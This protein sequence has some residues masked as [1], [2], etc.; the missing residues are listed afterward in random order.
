[1]RWLRAMAGVLGAG[2]VLGAVGCGSSGFN[3]QS[4][5]ALTLSFQGFNGDGLT[6]EDFVGNTSADVDVCASICSVSGDFLNIE[7][8]SFTSTR[9]NAVFVNNGTADILLDSYTVSIPGSDIPP[10]VAN[11]AALIPGGRCVGSPTTHCGFDS[12]CGFADTCDHVEVPVEILLFD[13]TVKE[14][15]R[16]DKTCPTV[17]VIDK[18]IRPGTVVPQTYQTNVKFTGSDETGQDFSI[19][20]GL[21]ADFFDANNCTTSGGTGG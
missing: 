7:F 16:G 12:D 13:F 9:A 3:G 8:E 11:I 6:Q 5:D 17:D 15:I 2:L 19:N 21:V 18:L 10:R 20:T 4:D 14:L 1:M